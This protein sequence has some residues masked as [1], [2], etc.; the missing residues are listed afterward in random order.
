LITYEFWRK[1]R[2]GSKGDRRRC[3]SNF[4]S[5]EEEVDKGILKELRKTQHNPVGKHSE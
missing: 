4:S 2:D 1:N 5:G 3:G